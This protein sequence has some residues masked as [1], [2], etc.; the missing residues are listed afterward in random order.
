[1]TDEEDG[2]YEKGDWKPSES[3]TEFVVTSEETGV[4]DF[5]GGSGIGTI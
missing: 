1:M 2:P 3:R 4:R 5:R